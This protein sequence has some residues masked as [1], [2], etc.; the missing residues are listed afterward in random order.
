[1][2]PQIPA[3][4]LARQHEIMKH[5][6]QELDKHLQEVRLGKVEE[7]FGVKDFA[8][9]LHIHP[10]HLSNTI[11]HVTGESPCSIFEKRLCETAKILLRETNEPIA[12]I[13]RTMT[14]DP[15]NFTKFFKKYA[16]VTPREYRQNLFQEQK[17]QQQ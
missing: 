8:E 10:T 17:I 5:Y 9:L 6:F 15:S 12:E 2:S 11:K 14:Y 7:I 3:Q 4:I 16:G 13:A 1:M